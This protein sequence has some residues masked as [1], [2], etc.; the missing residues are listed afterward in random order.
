LQTRRDFLSSRPLLPPPSAFL[1]LCRQASLDKQ[2]RATASTWERLALAASHSGHD[3]PGIWQF[4]QAASWRFAT[5]MR[6]GRSRQDSDQW[7]LLEKNGQP[8]DGVTGYHNYHELLANKDVDAV[9]IS[10]PDHQHAI[11]AVD[12][13]HAQERRLPAKAGVLDHCR[14]TSHEQ[15]RHGFGPNSSG[16]LAAE[17]W[18]QF[19][20]ACE[21]VR[22]RPYWRDQSMWKSGCPAIPA[23]PMPRRC[24]SLEPELRRM[25]GLDAGGL[26]HRDPRPPQDGFSR[27][28][29]CAA[30][31]SARA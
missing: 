26:L 24:P 10:T 5:S 14:G 16:G 28:A 3:L 18:K 9:V 27:P 22:Q 20:R 7:L 31:S 17:M 30:S 19:H 4:D 15:R 11:L 6:I 25:A 29:G 12:A 21:L 8:Y 1:P 23:G 13:V 2:H